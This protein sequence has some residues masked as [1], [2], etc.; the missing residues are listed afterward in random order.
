MFQDL[1]K[2]LLITLES[3]KDE[4]RLAFAKS[5]YPTQSRVIG[6]TNPNIKIILKELHLHTKEWSSREKVNLAI[7]LVSEGTFELQ[8]LAYEYL[9]LNKRA[10]HELNLEDIEA[11]CQRMD[12]WISTDYYGAF[13]FGFA[14]REN[15]IPLEKVTRY[16]SSDNFWFR[17][18]PLAA[19][20]ALNQK[21]RGGIGDT[22]RTLEICKLAV[23]DY[24]DMI[25]K[26]LS[27]SLRVLSQRDHNA[28]VDFM[29]KHDARLHK[30][31][32][33]EVWKKLDTGRKN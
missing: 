26:A 14:W 20:T 2:D 18:I 22:P 1:I 13:I 21:A 3:F 30:R 16:M 15:I 5:V 10:K 32:I 33:R 27:W 24:Q 4:K 12:N 28:V 25:V 8:Q 17:R 19:T 31:V 29:N 7:A 23:D 11:L 6:V 9:E